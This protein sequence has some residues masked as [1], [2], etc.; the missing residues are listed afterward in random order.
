M[1]KFKQRLSNKESFV[2]SKEFI[3]EEI[4][5][6]RFFFTHG[7]EVDQNTSYLKWKNIYSSTPFKIFVNH[8]LPYALVEHFGNKASKDSKKRNMKKFVY[9]QSKDLY[10]EGAEVLIKKMDIDFLITGH[11]HIAECLQIGNS[12]Y[13]NNGFPQSTKQFI[14]FDGKKPKLVN[15]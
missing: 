13:V 14:Y 7:H 2:H 3:L 4:D 10:R 9:N 5:S 11:T 12:I 6:K 1:N 8:I 15:L